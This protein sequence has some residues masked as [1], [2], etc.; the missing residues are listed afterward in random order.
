MLSQQVHKPPSGGRLG[1]SLLA[2]TGPHL[3]KGSGTII[4]LSQELAPIPH[5]SCVAAVGCSYN[6]ADQAAIIVHDHLN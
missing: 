4:N 2:D 3:Q 5:A 1:E 6:F